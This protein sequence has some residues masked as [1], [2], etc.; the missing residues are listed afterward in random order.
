MTTDDFRQAIRE[1]NEQYRGRDEQERLR[2]ETA[3]L[4][5]ETA[6]L[7]RETE[8]MRRR[9]EHEFRQMAPVWNEVTTDGTAWFNLTHAG[10]TGVQRREREAVYRWNTESPF[11]TTEH[12]D[13]EI[14]ELSHDQMVGPEISEVEHD[15]QPNVPMTMTATRRMAI[16]TADWRWTVGGTTA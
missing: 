13:D 8:E 2:R 15:L 5:R 6:V 4:R 12:R 3:V 1:L 10:G 11:I 9:Q 16:N 7:R 14:S